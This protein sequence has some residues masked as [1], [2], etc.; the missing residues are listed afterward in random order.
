MAFADKTSTS[1]PRS[2]HCCRE[3][4]SGAKE[5]VIAGLFVSGGGSVLL[6][7]VFFDFLA[8]GPTAT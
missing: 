7:N 5:M 8:T 4:D 6:V 3:R 1:L 2:I